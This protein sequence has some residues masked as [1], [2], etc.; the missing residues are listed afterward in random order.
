MDIQ[1]ILTTEAVIAN[2]KVNSKKRLL[3]DIAEFG[4]KLMGIGCSELHQAL[5]EREELGST[6][7][8]DGVAIPHARIDG[9]DHVVG[10]FVKLSE[11]VEFSAVDHQPVDLVFALFAPKAESTEHLK[12]LARVSR[13]LRQDDVRLRLR[14]T[15]SVD[16]LYAVLTEVDQSVAA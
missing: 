9:I 11:P 7:M 5:V 13:V 12:A 16:A 10:V 4:S 2:L 3:K 6:A 1:D 14:S 8:G 15:E